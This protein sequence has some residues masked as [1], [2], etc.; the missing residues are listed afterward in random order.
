MSAEGQTKI[1]ADYIM[2]SVPEEPSRGEEGAGDCAV[3]LLKNYRAALDRGTQDKL[4]AS[5]ALFGFVGWLTTRPE[6]TI[7][8]GHH[9]AG[10]PADRIGEFMK[11]N[12]LS[13]PRDGWQHKLVWVEEVEVPRDLK[14]R[15]YNLAFR[16]FGNTRWWPVLGWKIWN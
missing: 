6:E 10:K 13:E 12:Q 16:L 5:E 2:A 9:D 8:S 11:A 4:S 14:W 7:M 15:F 3:R 1:I